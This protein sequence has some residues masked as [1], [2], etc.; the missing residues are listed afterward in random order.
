[1]RLYI[2]RASTLGAVEPRRTQ[3]TEGVCVASVAR[4]PLRAVAYWQVDGRAD[5]AD[6]IAGL[7]SSVPDISGVAALLNAGEKNPADS[8]A[9]VMTL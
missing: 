1:V 3:D 7:R 6:F 4:V 2:R 9:L 8:N 5:R